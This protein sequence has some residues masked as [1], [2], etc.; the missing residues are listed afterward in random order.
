M[1]VSLAPNFALKRCAVALQARQAH[2]NLRHVSV[3]KICGITSTTESA[4]GESKSLQLNVTAG[5]AAP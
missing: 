2:L 4:M 3:L 1:I 5:V